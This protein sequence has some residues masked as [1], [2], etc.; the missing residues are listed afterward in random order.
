MFDDVWFTINLSYALTFEIVPKIPEVDILAK[1][2][3][4]HTLENCNE[5]H[6]VPL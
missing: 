5:D 3:D 6:E 4:L 1:V 2:I